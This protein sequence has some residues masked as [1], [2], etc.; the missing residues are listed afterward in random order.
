MRHV[1]DESTPDPHFGRS[2][3]AVGAQFQSGRGAAN[4]QQGNRRVASDVYG[5]TADDGAGKAAPAVSSH[6]NQGGLPLV[7]I[8]DD[9]FANLGTVM[10]EQ[11][12]LNLQTGTT[13]G[14][15]DRLQRA[16]GIAAQSPQQIAGISA[17]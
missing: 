1:P 3:R 13:R 14:G 10:L 2:N 11:N 4:Q 16:L 7:R 17:T 8:L 6:H 9:R 15:L 5:V 12:W